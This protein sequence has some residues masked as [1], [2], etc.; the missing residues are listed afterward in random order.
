MFALRGKT[1]GEVLGVFDT[2]RREVEKQSGRTVKIVR[3]DNGG[4]LFL[5]HSINTSKTS[6]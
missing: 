2:W 5:S 6:E 3:S 1:A 4:S